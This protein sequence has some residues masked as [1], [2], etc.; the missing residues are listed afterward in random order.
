[1]NN[2]IL[3]IQNSL[4]LRLV[5]ERFESDQ[6]KNIETTKEFQGQTFSVN[7]QSLRRYSMISTGWVHTCGIAEDGI[8][9][10]G[11]ND[12]GQIGDG[13]TSAKVSLPHAVDISPLNNENP[14]FIAAGGA[15]TC[16]ITESH[17]VLC[18][19]WNSAGQLGDN[20]II[21]KAIPVPS[22]ISL[23]VS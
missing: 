23:L 14:I 7:D 10:F 12:A 17:R 19:G 2:D 22:N 8:F 6:I 16:I 13:T 9:C 20:S 1:M 21:D 18:W 4:L 5:N 15:H 3:N 11:E